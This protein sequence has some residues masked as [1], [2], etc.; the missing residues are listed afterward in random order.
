MPV[1]ARL[2]ALTIICWRWGCRTIDSRDGRRRALSNPRRSIASGK[3][4]IRERGETLGTLG[5]RRQGPRAA[6]R[7]RPALGVKSVRGRRRPTSSARSSN[8][9]GAVRHGGDDRRTGT[10]ATGPD[11]AD[12]DAPATQAS[13]AAAEPTGAT[14]VTAIEATTSTGQAACDRPGDEPLPTPV[15]CSAPTA[16]RSPSGRSR[17]SPRATPRPTAT[18]SRSSSPRHRRGTRPIGTRR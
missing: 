12:A 13:P 5:P 6:G 4:G 16:S 8:R 1:T 14:A 11:S 17:C 9:P 10:V 18:G 2:G 15:S 7:H 3:E